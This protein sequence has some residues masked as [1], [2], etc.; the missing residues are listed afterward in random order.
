MWIMSGKSVTKKPESNRKR[1][2]QLHNTLPQQRDATTTRNHP[3]RSPSPPQTAVSCT[4]QADSQ[5]RGSPARRLNV[6]S[7][8]PAEKQRNPLDDDNRLGHRTAVDVCSTWWL[9]EVSLGLRLAGVVLLALVHRRFDIGSL[10]RA[11]LRRNRN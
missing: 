9:R 7:D 8:A 1:T 3:Q 10:S 6:R 4:C 5:P 11:T 2:V